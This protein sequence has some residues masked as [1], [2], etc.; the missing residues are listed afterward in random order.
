MRWDGLY[1]KLL[2]SAHTRCI[3][4]QETKH[5]KI[6]QVKIDRAHF[7]V[8]FVST[9][10][11][12]WVL[13]WESSWGHRG[14]FCTEK[15]S[16]FV[17]ISVDIFMCI[18]VSTIHERVRGSNFAVRVLCAFL[19]LTQRAQKMSEN[20]RKL[21]AN[22]LQTPEVE[23]ECAAEPPLCTALPSFTLCS[24]AFARHVW[25]IVTTSKVLSQPS[26][27]RTLME[28]VHTTKQCKN[29]IASNF[30]KDPFTNYPSFSCW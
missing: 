28:P 3:V 14:A 7:R 23:S 12:P 8:H 19:I 6:G 4:G 25:L 9:G 5:V 18:F 26:P 11:F 22:F 17:G 29:N 24:L 13:S 1:T 20:V 16:S 2:N 27:S 10:K 15:A 30:C 21:G